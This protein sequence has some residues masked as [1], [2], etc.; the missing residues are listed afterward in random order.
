MFS[1]RKNDYVVFDPRSLK[2]LL[3]W[4]AAHE[5][6]PYPTKEEK[7]DLALAIGRTVPQVSAWFT[8][9]RQDLSKQNGQKILNESWRFP[10]YI[11]DHLKRWCEDHQPDM[12]PTQ[13]EQQSL[14]LAT[15]LSTDQIMSWIKRYIKK[16]N[17][18]GEKTS[19][20]GKHIPPHVVAC[21]QKWYDKHSNPYPTN[22]EKQ[23]LSV[24]TGLTEKQIGTWF[25]YQRKKQHAVG[26][27]QKQE[28]EGDRLSNGKRTKVDSMNG[29][30]S[31]R[32]PDDID[33]IKD[34]SK[35][36]YKLTATP[37]HTPRDVRN[38]KCFLIDCKIPAVPAHALHD[39]RNPKCLLYNCYTEHESNP[40]PTREEKQELAVATGLTLQRVSTWFDRERRKL[41]KTKKTGYYRTS[42]GS[43]PKNT[44]REE[45]IANPASG[46]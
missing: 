23:E 40:Y 1:V 37:M 2:C 13:E 39:V 14:S 35:E 28:K 11:N 46:G 32:A 17:E 44:R 9:H 7:Q 5:S 19:E 24:T 43:L 16:K 20:R 41:G 6:N 33:I 21:L 30:I 22:E 42:R 26:T 29:R 10:E 12:R 3:D 36:T 15:G 31:K 27:K 18:K 4:Y 34:K 45:S 38:P 8:K 25:Y